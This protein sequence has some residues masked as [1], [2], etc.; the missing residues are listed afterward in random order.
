MPKLLA[1]AARP[2]L[3]N[4]LVLH[5]C[6]LE[7]HTTPVVNVIPDVD[8]L[9]SGTNVIPVKTGI[10]KPVTNGIMDTRIHGLT[11]RQCSRLR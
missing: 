7:A 10:Y 4:S 6:Y 2:F 8:A 5:T 1:A 3:S 9:L 11:L